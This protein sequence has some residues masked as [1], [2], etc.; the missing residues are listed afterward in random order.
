MPRAL[1]DAAT[2]IGVRLTRMSVRRIG[3][4]TTV[5]MLARVPRLPGSTATSADAVRWA[6]TIDRVGG[7][8]YGATC[9]DRSV[10]LWFLMRMRRLDGQIRIGVLLEED[11]LDGHAWVEL[12]GEI[13]NDDPDVVSDFAVF[14][15][16]P[17]RLVFS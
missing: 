16:D 12:N 8:P 1:T 3:F 4:K 6:A 17:T 9:L 13:V 15:E 14:D 5:G 11:H 10:F 2:A 7:R